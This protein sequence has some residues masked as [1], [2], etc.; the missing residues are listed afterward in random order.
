MATQDIAPGL[1]VLHGNRLEELRDLLTQWMVRAPLA[2]LEDE[3]VLVQ[4]NGIAQWF[5]H[6]LARK[7]SAGG[8]GIGAAIRT[9]LP[10]QFLWSAFRAVLGED[11]VPAESA[12][13]EAQL[14]WRLWQTLPGMVHTPSFRPLRNFLGDPVDDLKRHSLAVRIASLFDQYQVYRADWLDDWA[15]GRDV[16]RDGAGHAKPIPPEQ[17]WQPELWRALCTEA[18]ELSR[19]QHRGAIHAA[20]MKR[21]ASLDTRPVGLP[22]RIV[23][24]GVTSLPQQTLEALAGLGNVSQVILLVMNPCQHFWADIIEDRELL[25]ATAR[26]QASRPGMPEGA[27]LET[28]HAHAHPLLASWGKQGRDYIRLLDA[29]DHPEHYRARF[30]AWNQ[31]ID[32][33]TDP[34]EA[35]L[36]Q[37]VQKG[38]LDLEPTPDARHR[39][40]VMRGDESVVFH[41]AHGAMREVE[42]LHDQLLARFANSPVGTDRLQPRDV[43]VMVPDI[44]AYA[45]AIEAVFGRYEPSHPG[46]IPFT[47]ADRTARRSSPLF[48]ALERLVA[49]PTSRLPLSELLD[50]LDVEAIQRKFH[51]DASDLPKLHGWLHG[52][53]VRWGLDASQRAAQGGP[54]FDQNTWAFGLRR[55]LFGYAVGGRLP[56]GEIEPYDEIAGMDA[57]I[58][59]NVAD[60]LD[61]LDRHL[62]IL[63]VPC[64]PS[65]WVLRLRGLLDDFFDTSDSNDDEM[66]VARL[67]EALERWEVACASAKVA[68]PIPLEVVREAWL[69]DIDEVGPSRRFLAGAVNFGS[70][71]PM[72]AIPFRVVCLLGM[73]DL[74]FPR[75]HASL[76]F[77]LMARPGA[78]R[79]GDRSRRTDDHYLFLEALLSAREA[80]HVSWVGKSARDNTVRPPSVLVGQLR[81]HLAAGW[82]GADDTLSLLEQITWE[83]P[84]QPFGAAY[85]ER[86]GRFFTYAAQWRAALDVGPTKKREDLPPWCPDTPLDGR[87]LQRFLR[88]PVQFFYEHRLKVHLDEEDAS[89]DDLE[90]FE[91]GGLDRHVRGEQLLQAALKGGSVEELTERWR[92]SGELPHGGFAEPLLRDLRRS[93]E[94]AYRRAAAARDGWH[95]PAPR[96]RVAV[97]VA[98]IRVE[99]WITDL[100]IGPSDAEARIDVTAGTLRG[101]SGWKRHRAMGLWVSHLLAHVVGGPVESRL[102]GV[103]GTFLL[104]PMTGQGE[105]LGHLESLVMFL[106]KGM[107]S[108]LPVGPKTAFAWLEYDQDEGIAFERAENAYF[109]ERPGATGGEVEENQYL[110]FAYPSFADLDVAGFRTC[111][112]IYRP[113]FDAIVTE[114][115]E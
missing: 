30:E 92:R 32:L 10:G 12:F 59:G 64:E 44:N 106:R 70:L 55:M 88:S 107:A 16:L 109:N 42:I 85:F 68:G 86:G 75:R 87:M 27:S 49:L 93:A 45:P 105:A 22:R 99:D 69:N 41:V 94:Q 17:S 56:W 39:R 72:R 2:P 67:D 54:A 52:S 77:D 58:V 110:Q 79:P 47:I 20:F 1:M 108:P 6:A 19:R 37:Q 50:L 24:F 33:F 29:F 36:L 84:L 82:I 71:V 96:R 114:M 61:M 40:A 78:Q 18:G 13:D 14:V 57:S 51:L 21:I 31:R 112:E 80:L 34:G 74:D 95:E 73:N 104:R 62:R 90:A 28:L 38:I 101:K 11:A 4:S 115:A 9:D 15:M 53:G 8:L 81:D 111:V 76:D 5:K 3:V 66:R 97:D 23:V 89:V 91:S 48:V 102:V 65:A 113:L 26:R 43:I 100:R 103:D 46:H 25:R 60:L 63:S 7:R 98:G 83:H 35:T